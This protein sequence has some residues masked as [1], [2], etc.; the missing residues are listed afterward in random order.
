[1]NTRFKRI[2][3]TFVAIGAVLGVAH[4]ARAEYPERPITLVVGFPAGQSSDLIARLVAQKL[5]QSLGQ[6]LVVENNAG[7]GG[8]I[9]TLYVK[10]AKP[11]GYTLL[12]TS[13]GPMAVNPGLYSSLAYDPLNDFEPISLLTTVPYFL[14]VHRDF[15]VNSV[16]ELVELAKAKPGEINYGSAGNGVTSHLAM[17]LFKSAHGLNMPHIPY[18][19]SPPAVNDLI[20]GRID[21]MID[22]GAA[23]LTHI[24]S[25]RVRALAVTTRSRISAAPSVPTLQEAGMDNFEIIGWTGLAAPKGTPPAVLQ[26]LQKALAE[27]WKDAPDVR[28]RLF[29]LANESAFMETDAFRSYMSSEIEKWNHAVQISGARVD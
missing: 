21:V 5:Q 10:N 24:Q 20:A 23:L 25:G 28:D 18:K 12:M 14:A 1:M 15:P 22:N 13:S 7:A 2:L 9:G 4:T 3:T 27:N 8:I 16:S 6:P 26:T 19:G 11:D 17:E 29:V